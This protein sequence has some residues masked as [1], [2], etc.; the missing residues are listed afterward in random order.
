[1]L[2][3]G[4]YRAVTALAVEQCRSNGE[5]TAPAVLEYTSYQPGDEFEIPATVN[6]FYYRVMQDPF[7]EEPAGRWERVE[8]ATGA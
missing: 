1:M 8:T 3:P 7:R 5:R 4:R 6:Q 2:R